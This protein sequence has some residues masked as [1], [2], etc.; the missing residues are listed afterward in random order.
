MPDANQMSREELLAARQ[1]VSSQLD[2]LQWQGMAVWQQI[3]DSDLKKQSEI[4]LKTI[5]EEIEAELA[6]M[7]SKNA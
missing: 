2:R 5:L 6:E 4:E 7:D 3:G 1:K